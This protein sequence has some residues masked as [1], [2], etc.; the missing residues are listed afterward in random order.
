MNLKHD[1][2]KNYI[3]YLLLLVLIILL[4]SISKSYAST[5]NESKILLNINN[6]GTCDIKEMLNITAVDD[7]QDHSTKYFAG[8]NYVQLNRGSD[9]EKLCIDNLEIS[10][11]NIENYYNDY[12]GIIKL[13]YSI[14]RILSVF[15]VLY[16]KSKYNFL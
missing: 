13:I 9:I 11:S 15:I 2:Y 8:S 6:N 7:E 3:K 16:K 14:P 1:L 4:S 12:V 10:K 5:I